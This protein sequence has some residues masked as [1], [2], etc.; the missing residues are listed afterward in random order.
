M[1]KG[2]QYLRTEGITKRKNQDK[3]Y[4]PNKAL[5]LVTAHHDI[6]QERIDRRPKPRLPEP[7]NH[8]IVHAIAHMRLNPKEDIGIYMLYPINHTGRSKI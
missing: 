5:F 4:T 2:F 8:R 6:Q 1:K 3:K 7:W